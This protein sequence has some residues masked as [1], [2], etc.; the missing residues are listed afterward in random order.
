MNG[1]ASDLVL[2]AFLIFC[3]V[4]ACL[5]VMPGFSSPRVPPQVRLFIAVAISLGLTPLLIDDLRPAIEG[6]PAIALLRSLGGEILTGLTIG[7]M[8][9]FF[10]IALETIGMAMAMAIGLTANLGAPVN[11][12]EPLPA[13]STL[14]TMTATVLI[15]ITDQHLEVFRALASSYNTLPVKD[16][17][18]AQFALVQLGSKAALAFTLA[19]RLG[20][21]FLVMSLVMNFAIGLASRMVPQIQIF[22]L[23]AP[24]VLF[25]GLLLFYFTAEPLLHLFIDAFSRFLVAG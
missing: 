4:G 3:R 23:A 7:L 12:D 11:E 18:S 6:G 25:V 8:G 5:M 1:P 19:L 17:F 13:I 21:P 15:F 22:F 24:V 20:G 16:G 2:V 10:F 9:R 14:M